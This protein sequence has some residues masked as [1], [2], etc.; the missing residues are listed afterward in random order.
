MFLQYDEAY[1]IFFKFAK[2]LEEHSVR[3]EEKR[4][5]ACKYLEIYTVYTEL[6]KKMIYQ[7]NMEGSDIEF[8]NK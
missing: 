8:E 6:K 3:E 7:Q 5:E 4:R 2:F 1:I